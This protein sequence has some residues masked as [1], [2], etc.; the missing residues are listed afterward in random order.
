MS[1]NNVAPAIL[2]LMPDAI[3]LLL[4]SSEQMRGRSAITIE[5]VYETKNLFTITSFVWTVR[6]FV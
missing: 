6:L 4:G 5:R 1:Q 3:K 2:K